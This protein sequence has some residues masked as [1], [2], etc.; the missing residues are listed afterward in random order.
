MSITLYGGGPGFGLPEVSPYVTKTEVQLRMAGLAY[1]KEMAAPDTSPK[2]QLPYID[3]TGERVADST[4]IR[5]HIERKYGFD[6]DAGLDAVQRAQ[7]WAVER[8]IENHL[9]WALV[10]MRWIIPENFEKG[11]AHFFDRAPEAVRATLRADVQKRVA[12]N[13]LAVGLMRHAPDEIVALGDR[14]LSALSLLLGDKP[15]L[16]GT[17]CCGVDATAFAAVAGIITPFF[18]SPLRRR[19]ERHG[20]LVAYV[21][22]MMRHFYPDHPWEHRPAAAA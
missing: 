2:G 8:M 22:R 21:E 7:A 20:N 9:N 17:A 15:C 5:A 13:V 12:A 4:F 16:F 6:F 3:D 10:Y 11:P 14:S 18:E 1:R 19:A